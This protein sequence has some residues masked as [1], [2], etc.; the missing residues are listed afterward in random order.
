[1]RDNV[2]HRYWSSRF[3]MYKGGHCGSLGKGGGVRTRCRRW[4]GWQRCWFRGRRRAKDRSWSK[5]RSRGKDR[6][7]C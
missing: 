7:R 1:M 6:S 3:I 4:W 5:N 2:E